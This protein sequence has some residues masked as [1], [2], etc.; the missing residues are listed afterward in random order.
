MQT[1]PPTVAGRQ[2]RRRHFRA[3]GTRRAVSPSSSAGEPVRRSWRREVTPSLAKALRRWY[4]MVLMLTT[5]SSAISR[6]LRPAAASRATTSSCD[7][8]PARSRPIRL[9]RAQPGRGQLAVAALARRARAPS[10]TNRCRAR[11]QQVGGP[12]ALPGPAQE[13]RR[14]PV[15]SAPRS[16]GTASPSVACQRPVEGRLGGF[17]VGRR[18]PRAR[19]ATG[20]AGRSACAGRARSASFSCGDEEARRPPRPGPARPARRR[21]GPATAQKPGSSTAS[22][23]GSVA[24]RLQR[25]E[26]ARPRRRRPRRS[27]PAPARPRQ[28]NARNRCGLRRVAEQGVRG[29]RS[30]RAPPGPARRWPSAIATVKPKSDSTLIATARSACTRASSHAPANHSARAR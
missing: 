22:R 2:P 30:R 7:V 15:R 23:F 20:P 26:H 3:V 29:R 5:S 27:A 11:R 19:R 10:A 25:G 12:P 8:R 18:P 28:S 4:S 17:S 6:L 16:N 21:T 1:R 13:P 9:G 14:P 24:H